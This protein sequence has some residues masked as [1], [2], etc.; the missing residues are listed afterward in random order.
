MIGYGYQSYIMNL[1]DEAMN[2]VRKS[3]QE[4]KLDW[5]KSELQEGTDSTKRN[6]EHVWIKNYDLDQLL[7]KMVRHAN[8]EMG[9]F[10]NVDEVEPVQ[11]GVYPVGGKYEWHIDQHPTI[12]VNRKRQ[13]AVRKISMSLFYSN[14]DEYEGGDLDL[15]LYKPGTDPR[16]QSYKLEKGTAIFFPSTMWHRVTPVTSGVR[17]SIVAWFTGPPYV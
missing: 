16:Y 2:V 3:I 11:F 13:P 4:T 8:Q 14:P 17:K 9:W 1:T 12:L 6:S 5:Q 7:M 10:L 15:E